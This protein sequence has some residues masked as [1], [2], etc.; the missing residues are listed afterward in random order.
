MINGVAQENV[1]IEMMGAKNDKNGGNNNNNNNMPVVD[2][3]DPAQGYQNRKGGKVGEKSAVDIFG[4][5][6]LDSEGEGN[7]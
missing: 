5:A 2:Y 6:T 7:L 4:G 3:F 1:A